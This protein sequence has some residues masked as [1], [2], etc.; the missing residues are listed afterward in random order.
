MTQDSEGKYI[1]S[2]KE[3]EELINKYKNKSLQDINPQLANE[4]HPTK[5]GDLKP[6]MVLPSSKLKIWWN[7]HYEEIETNKVFDF[8]WLARVDNRH[9]NKHKCPFLSSEGLWVG[10][11]DLETK[12][13]KLAQEWNYKKNYPLTPKDVMPNSNKKVWWVIPYQKENGEIINLEWEANINDRNDGKGCPYIGVAPKKVLK[14]FN[15]LATTHPELAKQWSSKNKIKPTEVMKGSN[16]KYIW[17]LSYINSD[18]R[19]F[20][21]EWETS[22]NHR[23][24]D[25]SDC[26]YLCGKKVHIGFNDLESNYPNIA[27]EWDYDKNYPLT[28][29]DVVVGSQKKYWWVITHF[30]EISNKDIKL[31]WK[32]S[33]YDRVNGKN[34]PYLGKNQFSLLIGFNDL[35]TVNPQLA[36]EWHPTKNG[37]LTPKDVTCGSNRKV[38][39]QKKILDENTNIYYDVEWKAVISSRN[40]GQNCPLDIASKTVKDIFIL[41]KEFNIDFQIEYIDYELKNKKKLLFDFYIEKDIVIEFDGKQ[42]FS[43]DY[44]GGVEE[45]IKRIENDNIKN[46]FCKDNNIALLRIPYIFTNKEKLKNIIIT[47][48]KTKQV[49]QEIIAFYNQYNFSNYMKDIINN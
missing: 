4:W 45:F 22:I 26:P 14:G 19:T 25:G 30:D 2:K 15:D 35:A 11:N 5:N 36:R 46:D 39:W 47:F 29:K 37:N 24:D 40:K 33:V 21:F 13:P 7:F 38:W 43:S 17:E 31:S 42:H 23:N 16:K 10:F 12:N 6:N 1:I 9:Y 18:G 27:K 48:I 34:C 3:Q 44:L 8:E 32:M 49:P 20:L 28:P 41:L